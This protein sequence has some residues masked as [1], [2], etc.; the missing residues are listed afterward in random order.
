MKFPTFAQWKHFLKVLSRKEKLLFVF[1]ASLTL[2]SAIVATNEIY[3]NN[4]KIIPADRG[5]YTEGA[6][7]RPRF[8]NPVYASSYSIDQDIT[9]LLFA[10][11]LD[12][13][14]NGQITS[15][16]ADYQISDDARTY[17]FFL[18]DNLKWSDGTPITADDA[19]YTIKVIQDPE[20][21]SPVRPQWMGVETEKISDFSFRLKLKDP[22]AAFIE[23]CTLKIIPRRAWEK[24]TSDNFLLSPL[25]LNPVVSGPYR[26]KKLNL[27]KDGTPLSIDLEKNPDYYGT[28]PHLSQISF[29]FY[30]DYVSLQAAFKKG[31]IDGFVP[32]ENTTVNVAGMNYYNFSIP[33]YFAVFFNPEKNKNFE[34]IQVRTALSYAIDKNEILNN[35]LE[36]KAVA[37]DS[38]VPSQIFGT[39]A[40]D[41][42]FSYDPQ[43]AA[44]ILEDAGY[45]IGNDGL[46]AKTTSKQPAFQFTKTLVKGSNL[47]SEVKELQKCLV[48][49]VMPDLETNGNFGDKTLEAVKQFQEKYRADIL[50][51]QGIEKANGEVKQATREKLNAVCF[52]SG[53]STAALVFSLTVPD[54]EPFLKIARI[55][56]DR[57]A[58]IGITA[59]IKPV[60]ITNIERDIVKLREYDALLFGQ[61]LGTI[62][63]PYPFWH[64]SQVA[65]PGLNFSSFANKDAD[66]L[67]EEIRALTDK[68]TRNEKIAAF[69]NLI[70]REAPAIFLYNPNYTYAVSQKIKGVKTGI[71]AD[72]SR[73]FADIEEWY[74]TTKRIFK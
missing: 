67:L 11:L 26:V 21:K 60:A 7:G 5:I 35:A 69:Q 66:K 6:I 15:G 36:N 43:K 57:W 72:P 47:T 44:Q 3:R 45:K 70:I 24:I 39:P 34:D 64:S 55:I 1:F 50:D 20:F 46:R 48:R 25:N 22:Y 58:A 18:K 42:V 59:E 2:V 12:Y 16:L 30:D 51:P 62:P 74:A 31:K 23:N 10:G 37:V 41:A 40:P 9:E 27:D 13:G 63:D 8:L 65:D 56:K 53:N 32:P 28:K 68:N 14:P 29:S 4:T 33:R 61:A 52:P 38:P 49:E 17:E 19:I 73:R 54:Q 71:I